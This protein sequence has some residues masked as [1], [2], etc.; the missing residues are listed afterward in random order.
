MR[1]QVHASSTMTAKGPQ[2]TTPSTPQCSQPHE[3]YHRTQHARPTPSP[4]RPQPCPP[5]D[6]PS[7]P[8]THYGH[9]HHLCP[10]SQHWGRCNHQTCAR[11]RHHTAFNTG[12]NSSINTGAIGNDQSL[13]N[14]SG[15]NAIP[16]G[17]RNNDGSFFVEGYLAIFWSSTEFGTVG[18]WSR[19]LSYSVSYLN[20]P[21]YNEHYGVSVRFVRD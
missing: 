11:I 15:F 8:A 16:E 9:T 5:R 12:W 4:R 1:A 14:D 13:N 10:H 17:G 18:A 20:S 3:R 19:T 2:D 7:A 21:F 6:P